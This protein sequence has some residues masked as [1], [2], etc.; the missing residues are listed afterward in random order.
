[1]LPWLNS[2][3]TVEQ[4][5]GVVWYDGTDESLIEQHR[6]VHRSLPADRRILED[7]SHQS[8]HHSH[9]IQMAD[10][11]AHA[12]FKSIRGDDRAESREVVTPT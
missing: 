4:S 7:V 2:W 11:C 1:L 12:A 5:W 9:F 6:A 10:L 3:L 8:S